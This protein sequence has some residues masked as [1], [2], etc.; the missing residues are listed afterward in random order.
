MTVDDETTR[1]LD[2][3]RETLERLAASDLPASEWAEVLLALL[4]DAEGAS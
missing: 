1:R 4:D 3:R 2:E